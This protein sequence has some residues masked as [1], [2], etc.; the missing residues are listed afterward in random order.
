MTELSELVEKLWGR[1]LDL[2]SPDFAK[3]SDYI[4]ARDN[5]LKNSKAAQRLAS[6]KGGDV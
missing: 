4:K 5:Y 6:L 2:T 1:A 3:E